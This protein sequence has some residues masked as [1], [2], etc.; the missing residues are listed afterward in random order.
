LFDWK[1]DGLEQ[2][3]GDSEPNELG[4]Q[5]GRVRRH[6]ASAFQPDPGQKKATDNIYRPL[7]K[8]RSPRPGVRRM[9]GGD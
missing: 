2:Q 6:L 9:D 5:G 3:H 7:V 1:D 4:D 8:L